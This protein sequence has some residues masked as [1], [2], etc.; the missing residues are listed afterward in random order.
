[1]S[2]LAAAVPAQAFAATDA[3]VARGP[4][5]LR[6]AAS[7]GDSVADLKRRLTGLTGIEPQRQQLVLAGRLLP[8]NEPVTAVGGAGFRANSSDAGGRV[9]LLWP[10]PP[11]PRRQRGGR[12]QRQ[13]QRD[14][15]AAAAPPP[16][17]AAAVDNGGDGGLNAGGNGAGGELAVLV[18]VCVDVTLPGRV[19]PPRP[20]AAPRPAP[21]PAAVANGPRLVQVVA[22]PADSVADLKR[23]LAGATGVGPQRQRLVLAGRLLADDEPVAAAGFRALGSDAGGRVVLLWPGPPPPPPAPAR[24]RRG[25]RRQLQPPPLAVVADGRGLAVFVRVCGDVALPG[26]AAP[27]AAPGPA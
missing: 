27:P 3:A 14:E 19:A 15:I 21:P 23:R 5:L 20:A 25:G 24:R 6:V 1:M 26:D 4:R 10:A 13:R 18:R 7:P 2:L 11:P 12:R 22:A 9:V 17:A 8:D 16:P